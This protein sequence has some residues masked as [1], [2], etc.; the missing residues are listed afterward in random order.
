MLFLA[1]ENF[2]LLSVRILRDIGLNIASIMEDSPRIKD[3]EVL[4]RAVREERI[5]LTFDRDY[6]ELIFRQFLPK[7]TGVIYFRYQ[8]H[9]PEEPAQHLI[10]LLEEKNLSLEKMFTVLERNKIRQRPLH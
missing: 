6:G 7:P 2:P 5:I 10:N 8:P 4:A 1:N 9:T 3:P